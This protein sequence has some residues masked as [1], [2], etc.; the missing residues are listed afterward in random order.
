MLSC[1]PLYPNSLCKLWTGDT[2]LWQELR[3]M[4]QGKGYFVSKLFLGHI[5]F[6][7]SKPKEKKHNIEL[8]NS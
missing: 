6:G 5:S 3:E 4:Q 8:D 1:D 2:N 7:K